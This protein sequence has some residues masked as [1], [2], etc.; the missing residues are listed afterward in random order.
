MNQ[1]S[2][3]FFVDTR[4][5]VFNNL[6]QRI[7]ES[8]LPHPDFFDDC[9]FILGLQLQKIHARGQIWDV[10]EDRTPC[11]KDQFWKQHLTKRRNQ[12]ASGG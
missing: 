2:G 12:S 6:S 8:S 10:H 11:R 9:L 5:K 4:E 3:F 7:R 1:I